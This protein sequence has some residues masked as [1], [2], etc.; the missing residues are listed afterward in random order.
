MQGL[1]EAHGT[2]SPA[3]AMPKPVVSDV[4][5]EIAIVDLTVASKTSV[6]SAEHSET[7]P[8]RKLAENFV[9]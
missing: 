7:F 5:F 2:S 6:D 9:E 4:G 1:L 3:A 8:G